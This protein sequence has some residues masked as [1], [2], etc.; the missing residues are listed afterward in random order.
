MR[1]ILNQPRRAASFNFERTKTLKK[2]VVY[3]QTKLKSHS[4]FQK[5]YFNSEKK[6]HLDPLR[7]A[8]FLGAPDL[9]I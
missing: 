9:T 2:S 3:K 5:K 4:Q 7:E 6:I 8:P 1:S